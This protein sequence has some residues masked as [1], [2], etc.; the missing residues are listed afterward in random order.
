R[1]Q[2]DVVL[3][4]VRAYAQG[5]LRFRADGKFGVEVIRKYSGETDREVLEAAYL[6][7]SQLMAGTMYPTPEGVATAPRM[8]HRPRVLPRP[9]P[10]AGVLG[11]GPVAPL[12]RAGVSGG[13]PG[14]AGG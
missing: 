12:P 2:P 9:P 6:Y 4:Y 7:F 11:Q 13:L 3:R 5:V 10:P 1:A 8:L 14:L